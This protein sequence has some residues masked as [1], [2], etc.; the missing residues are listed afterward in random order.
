[1][2]NTPS[3]VVIAT[4]WGTRFGGIN[5]FSTDL[6]RALSRVLK[7]HKV[8]CFCD[9]IS[10]D[11]LESADAAGV[12]LLA[13][14]RTTL[15]SGSIISRE[16]LVLDL[17]KSKGIGLVEWWIG[18]DTIT[19]ELALLCSKRC[20][21]SR[22]AVIMHMSYEDY[23]YMKYAP[24]E[25]NT[26]DRYIEK[27]QNVLKQ[28]NVGLAVGPLLFDRLK[29]IRDAEDR[30]VMLVPGL[31]DRP[32]SSTHLSRL[33]A[34]TYG[35]F[36]ASES[37]VKQVEL[38]VAA[39]SR[40]V[41]TGFDAKNT[42]L[43]NA[44]LK[45]SGAS[46]EVTI[47]LRQ[48]AEQEAGRVINLKAHDFVEER[49][50]LLGWLETSNLCLML[51][52]HEGFGLSAWEAIGAGV[53]IVLT[54][55]SGVYKLLDAIG[56][57]AVGCVFEVDVSGRGDG[58]PNDKDVEDAKRAILEAA[59]D[60]PKALANARALRNHLRRKLGFT[61]DRTAIDFANALNLPAN[62]TMLDASEAISSSL[63]KEPEDVMEG[64][65]IAAAQ[66]VISYAETYH[67]A[68]DYSQSLNVL[69]G[70]K[71][72]VRG[73]KNASIALDATIVEAEVRLR[74]NQYNKAR[75]LVEKAAREAYD[76]KDWVRYVRAR[77]VE[78]IIQRD[79]SQYDDAVALAK[80][81]H[82][83]AYKR[84]LDPTCL[85]K[86]ERLL[87]RSLGFIGDI[88]GALQSARVAIK[89]SQARQDAGAESKG[90]F[91]L[92]EAHR[93]GGQQPAAVEAYKIA[94]DMAGRVGEADCFIWS[95][96]GLSDSLFLV[97]NYAESKN[98]I[99][100]LAKY[101]DNPVRAHPLEALH[102]RLSVGAIL[103]ASKQ[104]NKESLTDLLK[105]YDKLGVTWPAAYV[106]ALLN[107][108][109]DIPKRF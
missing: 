53:P 67:S 18:H 102:I 74:L 45:I 24:Q 70:L 10:A 92:G 83:E 103:C 39:F 105:E 80:S 1:M 31:S 73:Y 99:E 69:E 4:A 16:I 9:E 68:G 97:K 75:S 28:A 71:K 93:H 22:S 100:R 91:A 77:S 21:G 20:Q 34:I 44:D 5:S 11:D 19:G 23:A 65:E 79:Q 14:E 46:N 33:H 101:V 8:I 59:S 38:A 62:V 26:V 47:K 86:V 104:E 52:W 81:L 76:I 36:S 56:G 35:R 41:K 27:Q 50:R 84:Q 87:S 63:L 17:I 61:W 96:L 108:K 42:T 40:A 32:L 48:L 95:I 37:L 54:R 29:E 15:K 85:E 13:L 43:E 55:N 82:L 98:L 64:S 109:F 106:H 51:S 25:A 78:I 66:R 3:I 107:N 30:S 89:L 72:Q 94:R 12:Q 88:D 58:R 60:L 7:D 49:E 2:N 90:Q 57:P 6:C